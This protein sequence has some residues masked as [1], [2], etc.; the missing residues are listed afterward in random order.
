MLHELNITCEED[1]EAIEKRIGKIEKKYQIELDEMQKTA[2]VEAAYSGLM[3]L[4]GGPGT[5]KTTTINAMIHY[6]EAEGLDIFLAARP[7][8]RR[9]E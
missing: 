1:R 6:F 5:G 2:V 9:N 7:E 3:I 8:E 4:T